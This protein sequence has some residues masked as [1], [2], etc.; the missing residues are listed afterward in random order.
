M[1]MS[2]AFEILKTNKDAVARRLCWD[3]DNL[4]KDEGIFWRER[5][6]AFCYYY[7]IDES[8]LV[9]LPRGWGD[10][11]KIGTII[12]MIS[13]EDAM[14]DDWVIVD[15]SSPQNYQFADSDQFAGTLFEG[16]EANCGTNGYFN[17]GAYLRDFD[18]T[19]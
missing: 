9:P 18:I 12:S 2:E 5:E 7:F 1:T 13:L 11:P 17:T 3:N 15:R 19:L 8:S 6:G 10:D 16:A 14:A 4:K